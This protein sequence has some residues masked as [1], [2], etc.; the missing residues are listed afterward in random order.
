MRIL[1]LLYLF[2]IVTAQLALAQTRISDEGKQAYFRNCLQ[3][4]DERISEQTH[5]IF[6]QC[7]AHFMQQNMSVEEIQTMSTQTQDARNILNKVVIQVYAPCM[8]FPVRDLIY[9][10][11]RKEKDQVSNDICTCLADEMAS[12]T[13]QT[14][15]ERLTTV[16][17]TTP[18]ITDPMDPIINSDA[19][20]EKEKMVAME[21]IQANIR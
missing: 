18:N 10:E 8:E 6:C 14:A 3:Q 12:Y 15:Q 5:A 13:A 20:H 7:T 9:N 17:Q 1:L 21:C 4:T 2:M 11:C 19:F 16:L